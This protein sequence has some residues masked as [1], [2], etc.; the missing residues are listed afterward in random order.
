ML[1]LLDE[2]LSPE[3]ARICPPS[4]AVALRDWRGGAMLGNT[5]GRLL[6]EAA[7]ERLVLV[8][9]D[10]ATIPALLQ[11]MAASGRGHSGVVLISSRSFAQNDHAAI[12]SSLQALLASIANDD[13]TN[14]VVFLQKK[15]PAQK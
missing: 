4:T 6:E 9:F 13:W 10:L 15:T 1:F 11:E 8:T 7:R 5:D 12:A 2:H 14:R 3:V